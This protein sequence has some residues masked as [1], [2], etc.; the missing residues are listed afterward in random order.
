M[1]IDLLP[2]IAKLIGA[3]TTWAPDR[4]EKYFALMLKDNAKSPQKAYYFY[5]GNQLQAIKTGKMEATLSPWL[6]NHGRQTRGQLEE[7]LQIIPRLRLNFPFLT[8]KKIFK[9]QKN[10]V[11]KFP[12]IVKKLSELGNK[13]NQKLKET[14]RQPG[15]I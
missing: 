14:K 6:Q 10:L 3:K 5:Y 11:S 13:F 1:T 7:F 15:K 8:W 12:D 2:T 9:N 4:R